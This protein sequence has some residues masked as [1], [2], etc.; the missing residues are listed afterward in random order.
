MPPSRLAILLALSA[1]LENT[2][3]GPDLGLCARAPDTA[4]TYGE[5]E[6][7]TCLA[8]PTD[9][10]FFEMDGTTWLAVANADAY[11]NYT[12]GSVLLIDWDDIDFDRPLNLM[13]ELRAYATPSDRFLGSMALVDDRPDGTRLLLVPTRESPEMAIGTHVDD[14]LVFDATDPRDIVPWAE[15][16]RVSAGQDPFQAVVVEDSAFVLNLSGRDIAVFDTHSTPLE[17]RVLRQNARI[18]RTSFS[19][20]SQTGAVAELAAWNILFDQR[21]PGD[22][23]TLSWRDLSYR[24]WVPTER[25]FVR[26]NGGDT[27]LVDAATGPDIPANVFPEALT[28]AFAYTFDF[29]GAPVPSV[30]FANRG[31]L[32]SASAVANL[33]SWTLDDEVL[34]RGDPRGGWASWLDNPCRFQSDPST[35]IAFDARTEP[36]APASIG[37]ALR[38]DEFTYERLPDPVLVPPEGVS[39]EAPMVRRD[40]FTGGLRMWLTIRQGSAFQI[41]LSEATGAASFAAPAPVHGLPDGAAHP[42][43]ARVN[44]RY[45]MW[46]VVFES[47]GWWLYRAWSFDGQRWHDPSPVR[48]MPEA[49]DPQVPPRPAVQVDPI[50]GFAVESEDLG[51]FSLPSIFARDGMNF[52]AI[53]QAGLTFRVATG[54]ATPLRDLQRSMRN[55]LTPSSRLSLD[56]QELLFVTSLGQDGRRHLARFDVTDGTPSA[57]LADLIALDEHE[58]SEAFDPVV[59]GEAGQLS[60]LFGTRGVDGAPLIRRATSSDGAQWTLQEQPA[61]DTPPDFG[62]F[63]LSPGSIQPLSGGRLRLW[64]AGSEGSRWRIGSAI[65]EDGGQSFTP[66]PTPDGRTFRVGPGLPGSFDDVSVRAP[67]WFRYDGQDYLAYSG[68]DGRQW[69]LGLLRDDPGDG[70]ANGE[71]PNLERRRAPDGRVTFWLGGVD[72][73]FATAG[74]D[75]P[76]PIVRGDEIEVWFAGLDLLEAPTPRLGTAYG[77]PRAI[78][79]EILTPRAGDQLTFR[80][81]TGGAPTR[82]IRLEQIFDGLTTDGVGAHSLTYDEERGLLYVTARNRSF[83]YAIDVRDDSTRN[84]RDPTYLDVKAILYLQRTGPNLRDVAP[85]PGSPYLYASG[86]EPDGVFVIDASGLDTL[87]RRKVLRDT[88]LHVFPVRVRERDVN[89]FFDPFA[90]S[91]PTDTNLAGVTVRQHEGRS[92]LFAAHFS[93]DTLLTFDLD[94]GSFGTLVGQ[95]SEIGQRPFLIRLS[96]DQRYA[97]VASYLGDVEDGSVSATIAIFDV[98]PDSPTF[99]ELL[100]TLGNR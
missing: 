20:L 54:H 38:A 59:H 91:M 94:R 16:D 18:E 43:V 82:S 60:M 13:H 64:Y 61:F 84:E 7:G 76:V 9:L 53:E 26:W 4:F 29:E 39:Y 40:P 48:A 93:E 67:R 11:Y 71:T 6:I 86:R 90:F 31:N 46:F 65:S 80:T 51:R 77:T 56:S 69:R 22:R 96:P 2:P 3:P 21:V 68:F 58:L 30:A 99:G 63:E 83:I 49:L 44:T 66:E 88:D 37:L 97:A 14:L 8:S 35:G 41:G 72:G 81:L 89:P 52:D 85:M 47:E 57:P 17:P 100:T 42:V 45:L 32:F 62:T 19:A 36:E 95:H 33:S 50:G 73:S 10:Q 55:G 79:P 78:F 28:G 34:L 24:V 98:D 70:P 1:C 5:A 92:H 25:G 87:D 15:G 74:T 75:S 12:S 23:W 27:A